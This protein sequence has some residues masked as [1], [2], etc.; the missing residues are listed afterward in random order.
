MRHDD[1]TAAVRAATDLIRQWD[2]Q[3]RNL[4]RQGDPHIKDRDVIAAVRALAAAKELASPIERQ[5]L[6]R[7][8][9][10]TENRLNYV[11]RRPDT[12]WE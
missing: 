6:Q 7:L 2:L 11:G 4:S 1:V 12:E 10:L 3:E 8:I 5:A 9:D